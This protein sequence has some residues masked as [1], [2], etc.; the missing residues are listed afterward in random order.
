MAHLRVTW[1]AWG[2]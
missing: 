1:V 2:W